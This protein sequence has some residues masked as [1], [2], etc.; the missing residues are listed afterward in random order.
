MIWNI[1]NAVVSFGRE[2]VHNTHFLSPFL[3]FPLNHRQQK[4]S[5]KQL[6]CTPSMLP[7]H[8]P[9]PQAHSP[10]PP[11][12]HTKRAHQSTHLLAN[13]AQHNIYTDAAV[14]TYLANSTS[15]PAPPLHGGVSL[16]GRHLIREMNR[17]G[18]IVDLAH[19]SVDTMRDVLVGEHNPDYPLPP[20][21]SFSIDS[22][23]DSESE[24]TGE[25]DNE[26]HTDTTW[27]GSL[28]PPI[29]SHSSAYALCPHPR[30]VPDSVLHL[31][32]QRNSVVMVNFNPDFI[33]C[34]YTS[35]QNRSTELPTTDPDGATLEKVADHIVHIGK[36]VGW[37]HVGI[38]SD[39]DGIESAPRGLEGV[40]KMPELV[41][42]LLRRGISERDVIK[43]VG[44]NVLRV[45]EE[46]ERV[47][48]KMQKA[49]VRPAE[50]ALK[51]LF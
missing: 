35:S 21:H 34:H 37:K 2:T 38:G 17:L 9:I 18:M 22:E 13:N 40:D 3:A 7:T 30:N 14:L 8:D 46:V 19:V 15:I 45:W 51:K 48:R 29:I 6:L 43:V 31:V 36:L 16:Q 33:S 23:S 20:R 11:K 1:T 32:A 47:G 28:A 39:F 27:H 42:E 26:V 4:S 5:K 50:D 49:G 24:G 44:G 12:P 25:G 41:M 10:V